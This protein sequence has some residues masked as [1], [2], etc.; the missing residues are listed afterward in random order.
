VGSLDVSASRRA[1]ARSTLR[2]TFGFWSSTAWNS[3]RVSTNKRT[4]VSAVTVAVR[5]SSVTRAISPTKSPPLSVAT[6]LPLRVT[7]TFDEHEELLAGLALLAEDLARLDLQVFAD[8]LQ[9]DELLA[10][11]ALEQ[12]DALERLH[13]GV[14]A[15]QPHGANPI[16]AR[17]PRRAP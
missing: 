10:G 4:G 7:C 2:S 12:R 16:R 8:P 14:L 3:L 13:L 1:R 6:R 11:K 9:L 5:G 17:S 15:E